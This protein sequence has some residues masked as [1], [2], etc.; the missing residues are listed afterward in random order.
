MV[1]DG[2]STKLLGSPGH[3]GWLDEVQSIIFCTR[4][5]SVDSNGRARR[6]PDNSE[7]GPYI[8]IHSGSNRSL[9]FSTSSIP[10]Q[11][12]NLSEGSSVGFSGLTYLT[13]AI[14]HS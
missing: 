14:F 7:N 5:V 9:S 1:L 10:A 11:F 2:R 6:I 3:G 13:T 8:V 4:R 12:R